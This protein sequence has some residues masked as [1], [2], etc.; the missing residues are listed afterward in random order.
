MTDPRRTHAHKTLRKLELQ[1]DPLCFNGCGRKAREI[2]HPHSIA[3]GGDPYADRNRVPLCRE[4]HRAEA[5]NPTFFYEKET[6]WQRSLPP[7]L[8]LALAVR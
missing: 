8:V 2:H 5:L 6:S 3:Q 4:C 7:S 1:G